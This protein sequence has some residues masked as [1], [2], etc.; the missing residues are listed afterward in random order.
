MQSFQHWER[1]IHS[2]IMMRFPETTIFN[3]FMFVILRASQMV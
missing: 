1:N 2:D 3:F